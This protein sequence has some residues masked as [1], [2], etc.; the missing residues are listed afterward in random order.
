[1]AV[2]NNSPDYFL[3]GLTNYSDDGYQK[4]GNVQMGGYSSRT[5]YVWE[6]LFKPDFSGVPNGSTITTVTIDV[7]LTSGGAGGPFDLEV[8]DQDKGSWADSSPEPSWGEN[9]NNDS[10][11]AWPSALSSVS[12]ARSGTRTIP[13]SSNLVDW[14]QDVL[15]GAETNDGL[16]LTWYGEYFGWYAYVSGITVNI[17]YTPP[18]RVFVCS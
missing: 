17:T 6:V 7:T 1:M 12:A 9:P 4:N 15:D 2:D 16:V 13:T 10:A 14:F 8:H 3:L 5:A 18:R 11:T